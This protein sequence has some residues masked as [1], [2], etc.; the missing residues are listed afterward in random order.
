M[1]VTGDRGPDGRGAHLR[2][3]AN[4]DEPTIVL[5]LE[6]HRLKHLSHGE[7]GSVSFKRV[8]KQLA[9]AL[10]SGSSGAM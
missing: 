3:P 5:L 10:T 6:L 4:L 2:S 9:A 7:M 1:D 8:A